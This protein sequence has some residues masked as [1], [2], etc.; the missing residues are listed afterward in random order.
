MSGKWETG[1]HLIGFCNFAQIRFG[2]PTI[3]GEVPFHRGFGF[4]LDGPVLDF[5]IGLSLVLGDGVKGALSEGISI[6]RADGKFGRSAGPVRVKQDGH[7]A[8]TEVKFVAV[9]K[10]WAKHELSGA[11]DFTGDPPRAGK[12][13]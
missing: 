10:R 4:G 6:V 2:F 12:N 5:A 8:L 3:G 7:G 13:Q 11:G 9:G 1:V